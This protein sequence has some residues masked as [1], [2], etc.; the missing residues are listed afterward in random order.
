MI[1]LYVA[2]I[3]FDSPAIVEQLIRMGV[4]GPTVD[5][6]GLERDLRQLL[7]RYIGLPLKDISASELLGKFN[8]LFMSTG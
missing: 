1:R 5:E 4:A 7:R 2:V 3:Q 8:L 6:K